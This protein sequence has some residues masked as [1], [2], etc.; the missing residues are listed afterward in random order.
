[1]SAEDIAVINLITTIVLCLI[2]GLYVLITHRIQTDQ[3]RQFIIQNRPYFAFD[4][5][6]LTVEK[7]ENTIRALQP[8]LQFKNVG[9]VIVEYSIEDFEFTVNG[10]TS[11]NKQINSKGSHVFPNMDTSFYFPPEK[12]FNSST[13]K[14]NNECIVKY[15]LTYR[16][17]G[18][19]QVYTSFKTMEFFFYP[20]SIETEL[21]IS[22]KEQGET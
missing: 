4:N 22:F 8:R 11:Q 13:L 18:A 14:D 15:R 16:I 5:L 19:H 21:N 12:S 6:H 3:R 9:N 20:L 17:P 2:T 7:E 1:M 10:A